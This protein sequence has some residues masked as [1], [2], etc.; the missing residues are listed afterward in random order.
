MTIDYWEEMSEAEIKNIPKMEII[1]QSSSFH[2]E[3]IRMTY[4]GELYRQLFEISTGNLIASEKFK[5]TV[6]L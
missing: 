2:I 1:S 5:E 6:T 3:E 4:K